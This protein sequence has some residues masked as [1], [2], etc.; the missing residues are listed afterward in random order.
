MAMKTLTVKQVV[1][2][3]KPHPSRFIVARAIYDSLREVGSDPQWDALGGVALDRWIDAAEAAL[4]VMVKSSS[5][6][7][8]ERI[9]TSVED[10]CDKVGSLRGDIK[11]WEDE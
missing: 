9:R 10:L 2:R 5:I 1:G 11:S 8:W 4:G 3:P 6:P 7:N